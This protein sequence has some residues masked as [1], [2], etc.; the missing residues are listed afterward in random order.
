VRL[1]VC[2]AGDAYV[3]GASTPLWGVDD[4][5]TWQLRLLGIVYRHRRT[6]WLRGNSILL[7]CVMTEIGVDIIEIASIEAAIERH[8]DRFLRRLYTERE[9]EKYCDRVPS[10][11]TRFAAKEAIMKVLGTGYRGV[12]WHDMEILSDRRGKPV[13]Y[14]HRRARERA[15]ALGIRSVTVSLSDSKEYAVAVALGN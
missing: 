15:E 3:L 12:G 14:L 13:V 4:A 10:L 7:G 8:G 6:I 9:I 2:G 5:V 11:A 1:A